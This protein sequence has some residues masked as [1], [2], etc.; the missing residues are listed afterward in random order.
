MKKSR[1]I[2][3]QKCPVCEGTKRVWISQYDPDNSASIIGWQICGVCGGAGIIPMHYIFTEEVKKYGMFGQLIPEEL[4][5]N[6]PKLEDGDIIETTV[7]EQLIYRASERGFF[8]LSDD[9][10]SKFLTKK[11]LKR[12][13]RKV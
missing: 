8:I 7:G 6:T 5:P 2:P 9:I 1:I 3:Y 4:I 10:M 12:N 11:D 13:W